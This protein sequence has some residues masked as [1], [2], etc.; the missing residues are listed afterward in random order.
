MRTELAA[1]C[2]AVLAACGS[3]GTQAPVAATPPPSKCAH[4]ADHL[5][6][7]LTPTARD[8]PAE[9]LDRVRAMFHTRCRDDGW[10]IAAQECFLALHAKDEV[11][12]CAR[13]AAAGKRRSR[14]SAM[15]R[16]A[17]GWRVRRRT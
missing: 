11:D 5:L 15:S 14:L 9:E 12:R 10:S 16:R 1:V 4:V 17:P 13:A 6:S 8:A 3:G 7:L 2:I